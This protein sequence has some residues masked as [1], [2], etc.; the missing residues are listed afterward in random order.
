MNTWLAS[1]FIFF[2]SWD[3]GVYYYIEKHVW[4]SCRGGINYAFLI[5][6]ISP[7]WLPAPWSLRLRQYA[8]NS[9]C[10]MRRW[11]DPRQGLVYRVGASP[12]V[13]R[14][15]GGCWF[16]IVISVCK[17][18]NQLEDTTFWPHVTSNWVVYFSLQSECKWTWAQQSVSRPYPPVYIY[19]N[20]CKDWVIHCPLSMFCTLLSAFCC[21]FRWHRDK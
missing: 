13:L 21:S 18:K 6:I 20:Q 2:L 9:Y 19:V 15:L 7:F 14:N 12:S 1:H 5:R 11:F 10:G 3:S 4:T 17:F 16:I 8:L